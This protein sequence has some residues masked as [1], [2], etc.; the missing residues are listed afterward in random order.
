LTTAKTLAFTLTLAAITLLPILANPDIAH[1]SIC[2]V[3]C[4]YT[5]PWGTQEVSSSGWLTAI[6]GGVPIYSN[7]PLAPTGPSPDTY[8]HINNVNGVNTQTGIEWQCAELVNRLYISKGWITS[9]W[10]G[11]GNQLYANAPTPPLTKQANGSV[12]NLAV[13]DVLSMSNGGSFGHAAV[14]N[15]VSG[16]AIGIASQNTY[17]VYDTTAFTISG[18]TISTTWSNYSVIGVIHHPTTHWIPLAGD[19][20]G[21]GYKSIGLYNPSTATF[22]LRNSNTSGSAD[23]T[24]VFG[25]PNWVPLVGDWNNDGKDTIGV[26]DPSAARFYLS[27]SNTSPNSDISSVFGSGGNWVPLAGDWDN[28]LGSTIGVYDPNTASFYLSNYNTNPQTNYSAVFGSGGNWVPLAGNWDGY[29][30]TTI[31]V[32]NPTLARFYLSNSNT[33]PQTDY[34]AVFGSGG[35]WE[36]VVGDWDGNGTTTIGIYDHAGSTFYLSNSNTSGIAN[37][38]VPY[39]NPN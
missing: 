18:G 24:A 11:N 14:V 36:P 2:G 35:T 34:T 19:W 37:I 31:G 3:T 38:T 8:N 7:G 25:N 9:T 5:D 27:N 33:S 21:K 13:G 16:S 22:Y 23:I 12:T 28:Y 26:Y 4:T 17:A 29:L 32:Y 20:T 30:S 10:T 39:G 6:G 1:A 15:S